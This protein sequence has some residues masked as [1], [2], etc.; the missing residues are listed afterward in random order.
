MKIGVQTSGVVDVFGVEKGYAM[1]REAGFQTI[2]WDIF[3]SYDVNTAYR[4]EGKSELT[5]D[6]MEKM[7]QEEVSAIVK[8]GL[9]IEQ[10]HAH[11]PSYRADDPT[12]MEYSIDLHRNLIAY[13][14]KVGAKY[15]V[16]HGITCKNKENKTDEEI[17]NL[18][19]QLYAALIPALQQHP[20]IT[21]C[22]EN[23][24]KTENSV[25]IDGV[26]CD[27]REVN[28]YIDTLNQ[29][30]GREAFGFCLDTGHFRLLRRDFRTFVPI[31]GNRLKCLH[32][33][34]NMGDR[35][36]AHLAPLTGGI[37]WVN[38]CDS[39]QK[40]G[41]SGVLN[42]EA[43]AQLY[44]VGTFDASLVSVWLKLLHACGEA[45]A[46]KMGGESK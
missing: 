42:F 13:A 14:E 29:M 17:R 30:A 35:D 32:L 19:L 33:H 41:Y 37:Y 25:I 20:S 26:C 46:K 4:G 3:D 16:V 39:L 28:D 7:F 15:V 24:V 23:L 9:E 43:F 1:I 5:A 36:D 12:W 34:D 21:V 8:N 45:F 2:D 44:R 38:L 18:N 11:F 6:K 27:A 10:I 40:I 22:M 31:I